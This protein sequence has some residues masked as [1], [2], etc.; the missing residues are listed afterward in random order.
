MERRGK[1][2]PCDKVKSLCN[3]TLMCS[4]F[5]WQGGSPRPVG[6]NSYV[7][8]EDILH[9][10]KAIQSSVPAPVKKH[11]QG[12]PEG[13]IYGNVVVG[14][15]APN[16]A[17]WIE[18]EAP[19]GF[20]AARGLEREV[21]YKKL[22]GQSLIGNEQVTVRL[23]PDP[24]SRSVLALFKGEVVPVTG[25]YSGNSGTW[26]RF[27]FDSIQTDEAYVGTVPTRV[28][29]ING[30]D[31]QQLDPNL[32]QKTIQL[33]EVPRGARGR[34]T[35]YSEEER[36][37]LA[38]RGLYSQTPVSVA[39]DIVVDDM[40]DLY[41]MITGPVF[42]TSDLYLHSFHLLFDRM[43][44]DIEAKKLLPALKRLTAAMYQAAEKRL[45]AATT[46][47]V[48][49][50]ARRNMWFFG[51]GGRLMD[52]RFPVS[53]SM[54]GDVEREVRQILGTEAKLP[55]M[56][57]PSQDHSYLPGFKEDYTQYNPRG[58]YT[59]NKNLEGYFRAMMH[60]GRK[61][62]TLK[63][64]SCTL[65]AILMTQDLQEANLFKDWDTFS[66]V[67]NHLV[68]KPDDPSP[69]DYLAIMDKVYGTPATEQKRSAAA[70]NVG[71]LQKPDYGDTQKIRQFIELAKREL[72]PQRIV[73]QQTRE[74]FKPAA[75]QEQRLEDTAGFKFFGQ[76]YTLDAELFQRLTSPS[77][78]T[79]YRPKN[80]PS[81]LE[82][83]AL[84]GSKEARDLIPGDW[85]KSVKSY[86]EAFEQAKA[87]VGSLPST[88]WDVSAYMGWLH[89]LRSLFLP[90]ESQQFFIHAGAWGYKS[91]NT[92]LAS[93]TELKHDTILYA[94]Q[95]YAQKG[96][97]SE[98]GH[99]PPADYA[100]P[101]IKGFVEPVPTFF[102][103]L[104]HLNVR[105][106]QLLG[107]SGYL[108]DEYKNKL[109]AFG[110]L[111][112]KAGEIAGKEVGGRRITEEE[113]A[114]IR[115][116]PNRLDRGLLL[117]EGTGDFVEKKFLQM[118]LVAD[119]A[120]DAFDG[121]VLLEAVG[122]PDEIH[123]I[124]KDYWGGTRI[125]Q[126]VV[127]TQYEF[128]DS[129]RWTDEEWK[130][131]VYSAARRREISQKEHGWYDKLRRQ[132]GR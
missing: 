14:R 40:V 58:H 37:L 39:S 54:R 55:S 59:L 130:E 112:S 72:P 79:D 131:L 13:L 10:Y 36:V 51:V 114:W 76:R 94:E 38:K 111:V 83:M 100:P 43:L 57:S 127:Y 85:W 123:V 67:I 98:E 70:E 73:S 64:E 104:S 129:R 77:V 117:P 86:P 9:I 61:T 53:P 60:Y 101:S 126:G 81:S 32:N 113:Y 128:I 31:V 21:D 88:A 49:E 102:S 3:A 25:V 90:A 99:W 35:T 87:M 15:P 116:M 2:N 78:G 5:L 95:S 50:A 110:D 97:G 66:K 89:T 28:G 69:R 29:W 27:E 47:E 84:L 74:P 62:F 121:R 6:G 11:A 80:L 24:K 56:S 4:F 63:N 105:T 115:E 96:E 33:T 42:V 30:Q 109:T 46:D 68:G 122:Y 103:R 20:V 12:Q 119:V 23:L 106:M 132:P 75:T 41:Q 108:T 44:Q 1:H 52:E 82:I 93:W 17:Q 45:T 120:T 8:K 48:R 34:S 26:Y 71:A 22:Q 19:H 92:A 18:V 124:V 91:L 125:A 107:Q 65:S 7:V 118:A 16:N